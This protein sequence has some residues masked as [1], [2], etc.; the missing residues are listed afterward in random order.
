MVEGPGC[1]DP[2]D[3][4]GEE[5]GTEADTQALVSASGQLIP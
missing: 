5:L 4:G 2:C 3:V 1:S